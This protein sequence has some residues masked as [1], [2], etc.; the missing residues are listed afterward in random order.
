MVALTKATS[1]VQSFSHLCSYKVLA[2]LLNTDKDFKINFCTFCNFRSKDLVWC[3]VCCQI[4]EFTLLASNPFKGFPLKDFQ[5]F[6]RLCH[7]TQ[8]FEKV[9]QNFH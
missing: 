2:F 4:S 6:R 9:L 3:A 8:G 1:L 7:C 5:V